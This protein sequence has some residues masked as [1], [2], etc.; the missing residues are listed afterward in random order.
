MNTPQLPAIVHVSSAN[1]Q[2]MMS[3]RLTGIRSMERGT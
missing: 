1:E 3:G 2:A